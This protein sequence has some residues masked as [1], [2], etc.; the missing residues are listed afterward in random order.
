MK[1][2]MIFPQLGKQIL[3]DDDDDDDDSGKSNIG[4]LGDT[5]DDR[6]KNNEQEEGDAMYMEPHLST[7]ENIMAQE[8]SKIEPIEVYKHSPSDF[9]LIPVDKWSQTRETHVTFFDCNEWLQALE[10]YYTY[11]RQNNAFPE[12]EYH[13]DNCDDGGDVTDEIH[14]GNSLDLSDLPELDEFSEYSSSEAS[15]TS[16]LAHEME[17]LEL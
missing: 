16:D 17:D 2:E 15:A 14:R 12:D 3:F 11:Y 8:E 7:D 10:Q 1:L 6:F 5:N 13:Y 9:A 4:Y